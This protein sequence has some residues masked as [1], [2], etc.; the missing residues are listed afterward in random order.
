[1]CLVFDLA[2]RFVSQ[3]MELGE[4]FRGSNGRSNP[5]WRLRYSFCDR[6]PLSPDF[7]ELRQRHV[8][9]L[10]LC[11]PLAQHGVDRFLNGWCGV[12]QEVHKD[13]FAAEF[14]DVQVQRSYGYGTWVV[15]VAGWR[16]G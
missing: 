8:V 13:V 1:M 15:P 6:V 16:L 7:P 9:N 11:V 4:P 2:E 5:S 10:P 14:V 3:V 12:G